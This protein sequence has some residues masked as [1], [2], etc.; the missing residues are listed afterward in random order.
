MGSDTR[1]QDLWL[2]FHAV[3]TDVSFNREAC[4]TKGSLWQSVRASMTLAGY[5]PP[6]WLNGSLLV[7]GGYLNVLPGKQRVVKTP[8]FLSIRS[9]CYK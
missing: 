7:D 3:S 1:I 4:H 5:L 9:I 8:F 2:P 6:M